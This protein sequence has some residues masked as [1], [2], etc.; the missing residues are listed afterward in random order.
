MNLL[1]KACTNHERYTQAGQ[2]FVLY[3]VIFSLFMFL[4]CVTRQRMHKIIMN[5]TIILNISKKSYF[6]KPLIDTSRRNSVERELQIRHIQ[7]WRQILS[8]QTQISNAV[9][10]NTL[11]EE[12]I[13]TP[14]FCST[15]QQ[16]LK[17]L[18]S[19]LLYAIGITNNRI[20]YFI[21]AL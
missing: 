10:I 18:V 14:S 2:S 21:S 15:S 7:H 16:M 19:S 20:T 12:F 1:K 17:H 13:L 5:T 3:G 8:K 6:V 9:N 11:S 4:Y